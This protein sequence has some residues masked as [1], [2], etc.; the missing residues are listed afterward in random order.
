MGAWLVLR[1]HERLRDKRNLAVIA[2]VAV[3]TLDQPP[4]QAESRDENRAVLEGL[5]L[6][7]TSYFP[8]SDK[9]N[10]TSTLPPQHH[11]LVNPSEF[12]ASPQTQTWVM[13]AT[14]K[15]AQRQMPGGS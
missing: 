4:T 7:V 8:F 15:P 1:E 5:P 9:Q 6:R 2:E 13:N 3:A 10:K 11:Q 14:E 12:T